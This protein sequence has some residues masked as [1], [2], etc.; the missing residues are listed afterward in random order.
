MFVSLSSSRSL[1]SITH[2][3]LP[4]RYWTHIFNQMCLQL[5]F[6]PSPSVFLMS[7]QGIISSWISHLREP[8]IPDGTA[9]VFTLLSSSIPHPICIKSVKSALL[10]VLYLSKVLCPFFSF[11]WNDHQVLSPDMIVIKY[12]LLTPDSSCIAWSV[13]I[14]QGL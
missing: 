4:S 12:C 7:F 11:S 8:I 1:Y 13:K 6:L 14:I 9:R 5:Y 2:R 3:L 10:M